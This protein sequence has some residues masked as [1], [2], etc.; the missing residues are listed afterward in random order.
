MTAPA[1][2]YY[3]TRANAEA[4]RRGCVYQT[5]STVEP[6]EVPDDYELEDD[7]WLDDAE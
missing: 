4:A 7:D 2:E 6:T 1:F 3:R 5:L